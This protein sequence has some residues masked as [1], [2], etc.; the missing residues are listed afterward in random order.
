MLNDPPRNVRKHRQDKRVLRTRK[1]LG[2]ALVELMLSRDFADITV[3]E[4]LKRARVGRSTFYAHF[5][6]KNDL[7][8]S[9]AER[10][11]DRLA[12]DFHAT[13]GSSWR[14]APVAELFA[15]V[16]ARQHF[17]AA[18]ERSSLR[19]PILDLLTGHLAGIIERRMGTMAPVTSVTA[20][21]RA[22]MARFFA[23][24]IVELM[25]WWLSHRDQADPREMEA[26]FHSL[27]W[28]G[29][30]GAAIHRSFE[31]PGV[32]R[33]LALEAPAGGGTTGS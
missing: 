22:P 11:L 1:A 8:M 17:R 20:L 21:P 31:L 7:L 28:R 33:P 30:A 12:G 23:A 19:E 27:A 5:R 3:Q 2:T 32:D 14:L 13:A 10:Y 6:N 15:H 24:A 29:L 4:V 9:D 16:S 26:R 18:L 25:R